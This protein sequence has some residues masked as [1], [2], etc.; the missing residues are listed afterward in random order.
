MT[1][2]IQLRGQWKSKMTCEQMTY[3]ALIVRDIWL[4]GEVNAKCKL[5]VCSAIVSWKLVILAEA[6]SG[7]LLIPNTILKPNIT[8]NVTVYSLS[9]SDLSPIVCLWRRRKGQT[10]PFNML[11]IAYRDFFFFQQEG[12]ITV[13]VRVNTKRKKKWLR[14]NSHCLHKSQVA[15]YWKHIEQRHQGFCFCLHSGVKFALRPGILRLF[16]CNYD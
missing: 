5:K 16:W 4:F 3:K 6:W 12:Q 7:H 15:C 2:P 8:K 10:C 1:V 14:V 13:S 9:F 11:C